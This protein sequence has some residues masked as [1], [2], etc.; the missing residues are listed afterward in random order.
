ML[1]LYCFSEFSQFI[2]KTI[3]FKSSKVTAMPDNMEK[4]SD[5]GLENS[6]MYFLYTFHAVWKLSCRSALEICFLLLFSFLSNFTIIAL[7]AAI[8][9]VTD[10]VL[11]FRI[12]S[13]KV[14]LH[15][16]YL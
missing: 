9:D 4:V 12:A 10:D 3:L 11:T 6:S 1:N 16:P 15:F 2:S 13:S 14:I 7:Y 5:I 8:E